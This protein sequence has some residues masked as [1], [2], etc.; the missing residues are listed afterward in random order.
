MTSKK[1]LQK[2]LRLG[3]DVGSTTVK[4]VVIEEHKNQVLF[5]RYERH[6][7]EQGRT[8]QRLLQEVAVAFPDQTFFV[9]VC[10]SGG[11]PI[12]ERIGAY[13]IQEVVANAA[14]VRTLYPQARTAIELGGQDAKIIFFR[15]EEDK[16]RLVTSDMRMNGSCA[17]GTGAF[18]DEIAAILKVPT[19]QFESM[20]AKGTVVHSISGR[21]G[22]FAKTDIQTI[23]NQGGKREDIALSSFHAIARQTIGGLAQGLEIKP[24]VVFEGGP[25]TYNPTLVDVFA[26]RLHLQPKEIIRPEYSDT[27]VAYGAAIAVDELFLNGK[28]DLET[29][30]LFSIKEAIEQLNQPIQTEDSAAPAEAYFDS[31]EAC[32]AWRAQHALPEVEPIS[33]T[34]GEPLSVYIGVD[35][36]STTS[37]LVF[38]DEQERVIDR[39]YA[40]NEG[41][42]IQVVKNGLQKLHKK[43]RDLGIPLKVLG[44]GTTGYGE[45]L[46][47]AAF[48]GDYH[49]V[50]TVAHAAAACHYEPDVS[51]ILDIGGQDMKAIWVDDGV[52]TNIMLNEA[53]S[54]GCGSFLEK[55]A[56]SLHIPVTEIADAAFRAKRPANLGSRCT[57]FM[58]SNIITEQKNG[59]NADDILAG[60]C[61]SIIQNVFTKVVRIN[62]VSSLGNKIMVQGGTFKNDAVL[63]ALEQYVGNRHVLRAPYAGEMG[64]IGVALLTKQKQEERKKGQKITQSH[65]IGFDALQT[66]TYEQNSNQICPFC[67]NHCNR[68]VVQFSDGRSYV[69]GNRCE[70]GE[71]VGDPQDE[72]VRHQVKNIK[73]TQDTVADLY[74]IRQRL[75]FQ[76]YAYP[77][78]CEVRHVTI[79][80]PRVLS[81]WEYAPFWTTF[82]KT[83]GFSVQW[84]DFSNRT[85]Y[86]DG[87]SAVPSDTV[88]FPAKLVHGHLRNLA[89]KQ[90]DRIFMPSITTVPSENTEK[91]SESMC[92]VVKGYP[93]VIRNSDN[94]EQHWGIPFDAPLFHWHEPADRDRQLTAY[95][96]ETFG[97]SPNLTRASIEAGDSAQQLFI[98]QLKEEGSHVLQEVERHGGYAV[99]LA[100]RPYQNDVLVNHNL[101]ELF[102]SMG[103]PVLTADAL[104]EVNQVELNRSRLDIVNNFHARMLS[105]A[106]LAAR[107]PHLEY[108]QVVSFGCGHDAY[109]SDEI[110]R[111][112][113]EIAGKNPLILKMDEGESLGPLRIRVRSFLETAEQKG[114]KEQKEQTEKKKQI[115]QKEPQKQKEQ[116]GQDIGLRNIKTLSDPYPVKFTKKAF[117]EKTVLVPNT[118]HAFCR[119]MSAA[120]AKQG[121]HAVPLEIG[122]EEAIRL[123]KQYVHNDI[124][125]PAQIVIGEAL[126]ALRSGQYNPDDVAIGMGKYIGDCRLTHYSALLRKAL[127]DAGYPQV[128]ILTNDDQDAR[129][130]HPGFRMSLPTAMNIAFALPVIDILEELL[131]KMRPY[132]TVVGCAQRAFDRSMDVVVEGLEKS[133]IS[134]LK[135]AFQKAIQWMCEVPYDRKNLRPTVLIV[136]E[137]LLNFHPGAN[138]DIEAYLEQNGFEIIEARMTDVIRKSYYYLDMQIKEYQIRKPWKEKIWLRTANEIFNVAHNM[139]DAI[140]K[141]HPLYK[142]AVRL[143][144]L[145]KGSNELLHHTFDAGEGILIPG[146]I[147]HHAANGCRNM[148]ILQPFGCLPNHVVGRGLMKQLKERY[149]DIQILPLDYDPDVSFAN[150]ENRLQM[151]IMNEKS[152]HAAANV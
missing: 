61:R 37:K 112:M 32:Q 102:T 122:R 77:T 152:R 39:F 57:V 74:Q 33:Q 9:G 118:S 137:Y 144:D 20:A 124:C 59:C 53:C 114:Q 96:K 133:G 131:R 99:V 148:I 146:E 107:N 100:S 115:E 35:A 125:F 45:Q 48:G 83:L 143:P 127:D 140:A 111:L 46:L 25:L 70:R 113:N 106:I 95:M 79:G 30:T 85:M 76:T 98:R 73:R 141:Q 129:N 42:P 41:N 11:K 62:H 22:V 54:S 16:D 65:F 134:G 123:G 52:V 92:A 36:G 26:E 80:L 82:W 7:A 110:I 139:A 19:E 147:L 31:P 58:N 128:P 43:Y 120:M 126:A 97:I 47:N 75:L 116:T 50:E 84:S 108:V 24:P 38:L 117:H 56:D 78:L 142:P 138:H 72:A 121:L 12:A 3:I 104:P 51:F 88:C 81:N 4:V 130:L 2:S 149:P 15:Y 6:H 63:R 150:V 119:V 18:I 93:I 67:G 105:S 49:T 69:T 28:S 89:E 132:E 10:G 87:L 151:M 44:F 101:P 60:L 135:K 5:S 68:V 27:I 64:A 29:S 145:A 90:V 23:L 66:F 94:P 71:V 1:Q 103:I 34:A 55:F 17:G 8:V 40:N 14:A 136:G 109:L 86:E 13:Y 21:C 91:S